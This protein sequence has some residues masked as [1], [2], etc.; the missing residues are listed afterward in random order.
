MNGSNAAPTAAHYHKTGMLRL[1]S[2]G[3]V[4]GNQVVAGVAINV[5]TMAEGAK[6]S[7]DGT[8][9]IVGN[10]RDRD[11]TVL[12]VKDGAASVVRRVPLYCRPASMK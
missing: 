10:F 5:G 7:A 12:S 8:H 11:L 9:I 1:L 4:N 6:F 3:G 2:I